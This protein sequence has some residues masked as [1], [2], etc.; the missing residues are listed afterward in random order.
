MKKNKKIDKKTITISQ[1]EKGKIVIELSENIELNDIANFSMSLF[2]LLI[3]RTEVNENSL[4]DML[5]VMLEVMINN[6]EK[7][8]NKSNTYKTTSIYNNSNL[9]E[10]EIEMAEIFSR[11]WKNNLLNFK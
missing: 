2:S 8:D 7:D 1:Q 11:A 6:I 3:D 4:I 10:E 9:S 5:Q